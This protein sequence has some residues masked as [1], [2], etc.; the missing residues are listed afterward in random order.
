[1]EVQVDETLPLK[2]T[3]LLLASAL[4]FESYTFS[5]SVR[6]TCYVQLVSIL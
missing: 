4:Q 1:M 6:S 3:V 5:I 2:G